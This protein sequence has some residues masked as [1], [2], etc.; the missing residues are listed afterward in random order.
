MAFLIG[1][2]HRY[3]DLKDYTLSQIE[4]FTELARRLHSLDMS[5]MAHVVRHGF[6]ADGDDFKKFLSS[7]TEGT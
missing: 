1:R 3:A 5:L 7:L 6:N 2:G 4:G